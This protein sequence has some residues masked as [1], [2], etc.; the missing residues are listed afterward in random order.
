MCVAGAARHV[1][2]NVSGDY[3]ETHPAGPGRACNV[4]VG[5]RQLH[6]LQLVAGAGEAVDDL[7]LHVAPPGASCGAERRLKVETRRGGIT[8]HSHPYHLLGNCHLADHWQKG[9]EMDQD[10]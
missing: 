4:L 8:G 10:H 3:T 7:S 2:D 1:S 5:D 9:G 6:V